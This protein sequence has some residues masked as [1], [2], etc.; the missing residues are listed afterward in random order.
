MKENNK[1]FE[2]GGDFPYITTALAL[3][4]A[5]A[6]FALSS[7][8]LFASEANVRALELSILR[9]WNIFSYF[10]IH[11][12]YPHLLGNLAAIIAGGLVVEH[13]LRK[14]DAPLI[15]FL[16]S[17]FAGMMFVLLNNEYSVIGASAG[18]VAL[19]TAAFTLDPKRAI[20]N[21]VFATIIVYAL[22]LG[23]N[24]YSGYQSAQI[25]AEKQQLVVEKQQAI[26]QNN[27]AAVQRTQE[28]INEKEEAIQQIWQGRELE[29][30]PP[31]FE[32]HVF[33]ALASLAYI[34]ALR[35]KELYAAIKGNWEPAFKMIGLE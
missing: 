31:N 11:S 16:G 4:I 9:P 24:A 23:A 12:G 18:G 17:A 6:Y 26:E 15:F 10:F 7:Q 13:W 3:I 27:T 1:A 25:I 14:R 2:W 8:L 5:G 19:L 30:T 35:R 28:K 33:A 29:K 20:L 22:I 34:F 32:I 21:Y